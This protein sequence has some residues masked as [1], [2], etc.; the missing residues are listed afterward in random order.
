MWDAYADSQWAGDGIGCAEDTG[1]PDCW[2][3]NVF[4]SYLVKEKANPKKIAMQI[5]ESAEESTFRLCMLAGVYVAPPAVLGN[6][7]VLGIKKLCNLASKHAPDLGV[8]FTGA[9]HFVNELHPN[10]VKLTKKVVK[11]G[12][13]SEIPSD[14][15]IIRGQHQNLF[16]LAVLP[17]WDVVTLNGFITPIA[18]EVAQWS[19]PFAAACLREQVIWDVLRT[20]LGNK[21]GKR[22]Y[23]TSTTPEL[24]D[25]RAGKEC[26]AL[27]ALVETFG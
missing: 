8:A 2:I 6:V 18:R 26:G 1:R 19:V 16:Q 17:G 12:P 25:L 4:H 7:A 22:L 9:M 27:A 24:Q 10:F 20:E 13:N 11:A 14:L 5:T 21:D 15:A 23:E 3:F